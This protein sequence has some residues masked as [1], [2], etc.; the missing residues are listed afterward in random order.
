MVKPRREDLRLPRGTNELL[1]L[2]IGQAVET[3]QKVV[4]LSIKRSAAQ[5]ATPRI[6]KYLNFLGQRNDVMLV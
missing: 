4:N 6:N 5:S 2:F 1:D 3:L